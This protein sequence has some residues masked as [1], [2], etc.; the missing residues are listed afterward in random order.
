MKRPG[1]SPSVVGMTNGGVLF[2][3]DLSKP[4]DDFADKERQP[5]RSSILRKG[6]VPKIWDNIGT[7]PGHSFDDF[8][9]EGS[10]CEKA[11]AK[12]ERRRDDCVANGGVLF[13]EDL[14]EPGEALTI[15]RTRKGKPGRSVDDFADGDCSE[16]FGPILGPSPAQF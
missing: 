7:K 3:E 6:I 5:G 2:A 1:P 10:C 9:G 15:L 12:P 8:A 13:A 16:R 14:S 11:R 4:G